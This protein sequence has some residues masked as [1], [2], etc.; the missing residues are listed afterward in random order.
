[1]ILPSQEVILNALSRIKYLPG[2][3]KIKGDQ[4]RELINS[5]EAGDIL[6]KGY[7]G[8]GD[9]LFR[10]GR[11]NHAGIYLDSEHISHVVNGG[12][13]TID[14][15]DFCRC[16]RLLILRLDIDIMDREYF[17]DH[18]LRRCEQFIEVTTR[19]DCEFQGICHRLYSLDLIQMAYREFVFTRTNNKLTDIDIIQQPRFETIYGSEVNLI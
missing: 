9:S 4:T 16:D 12:V 5:C 17:I 1:M 8:Y 10:K 13:D 14:V 19:Y 15:I 2:T 6:L 7:R 18:C 11:Y 3:F